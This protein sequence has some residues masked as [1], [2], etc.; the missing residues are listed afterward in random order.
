[1]LALARR[2]LFLLRLDPRSYLTNE[3]RLVPVSNR[4]VTRSDEELLLLEMQDQRYMVSISVSSHVH[5]IFN[6]E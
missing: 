5:M 3:V 4:V 1:M 2:L 6:N